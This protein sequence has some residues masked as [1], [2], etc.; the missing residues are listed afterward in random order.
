MLVGVVGSVCILFV[1]RARLETFPTGRAVAL[2]AA[3]VTALLVTSPYV[4][5]VLVAKDTVGQNSPGLF[6][7][8]FIGVTISVAFVAVLAWFQRWIFRDRAVVSRFVAIA[9]VLVTV[10][11]F[12]VPLPGP[13]NYDKPPFFVFYPLAVLGGWSLVD[14]YRRRAG[15][16]VAVVLLTFVPVNVLALASCFNTGAEWTISGDERALAQWIGE[17]TDRDAVLLDDSDRVPFVVIG[18]RRHLWGRMGFADQWGYDR[19]EMSRRYHAWRTVYSDRPLDANTLA[20]L[21]SVDTTLYV[22]VRDSLHAGGV[23]ATR[24]PEYFQPVHRSGTLELLQVDTA[25][26]REDA[27]SGRFPPVTEKELLRE[28]GL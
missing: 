23:N 6:V 21:G 8:R 4:Y 26:C 17:H 9:A 10:T 24:H 2:A 27:A 28:S 22:I 11:A 5:S 1:L 7:R 16:A 3:L 19:L 15:V 20:T 14:L 25:R 12:V 13:N 18:P